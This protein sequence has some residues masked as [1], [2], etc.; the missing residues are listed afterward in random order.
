MKIHILEMKI[1]IESMNKD[2]GNNIDVALDYDNQSKV[3]KP[4]KGSLQN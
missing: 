2:F 1:S 4:L 3:N